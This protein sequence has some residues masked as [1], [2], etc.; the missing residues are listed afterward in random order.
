MGLPVSK[1][2][3]EADAAHEKKRRVAAREASAPR[4]LL[5]DLGGMGGRNEMQRF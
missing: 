4:P 2:K 1:R 5:F 3:R